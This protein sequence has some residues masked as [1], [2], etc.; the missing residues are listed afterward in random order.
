MSISRRSFVKGTL[1]LPV[2]AGASVGGCGNNVQPAP[3]VDVTVNDDI[4][5]TRYGQIEVAVPR[6]PDLAAVG[7]A[8]SLRIAPL[9]PGPRPFSIPP[10]GVLLVHRGTTDDPPEFIATRADCPHQG[11][12]LGY[13]AKDKL[14]ECP[15]H[16]SRFL[17]TPG[18]DPTTQCVGRVVHL[19]ALDNL[20]VYKVERLGDFAYVDLGSDVSCGVR[21]D[22]PPVVSGT[23]TIPLDQYPSL[24]MP[25]GTLVGK[26]VGLDDKLIIARVSDTEIVCVSAIC[27]HQGCTIALNLPANDFKCPC[28]G[29]EF[30]F[31]GA[32]K[33]S[34]A[35]TPVKSYAVAF[36]ST[37]MTAVITVA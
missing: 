22:L 4:T 19:P 37:A 34:P 9:P 20:T 18:A 36:D 27:T 29:S 6:Y 10:Q 23:I 7:G 21:T 31:T 3:L 26:P 12:P 32:V 28:H 25:G 33:S 24:Q 5:S 13:S 8:V 2:V 1:T 35:T 14:I 11:C 17:A 15:C 30:S 16:A